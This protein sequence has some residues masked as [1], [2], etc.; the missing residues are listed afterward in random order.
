M[1][2]L[3]EQNASSSGNLNPKA[4][5]NLTRAGDWT[6]LLG[7]V[8]L[9]ISGLALVLVYALYQDYARTYRYVLENNDTYGLDADFWVKMSQRRFRVLLIMGSF[10]TAGAS[11]LIMTAIEGFRYYTSSKQ[12]SVSKS[13]NDAELCTQSIFKAVRYLGFT[14]I[15]GIVGVLCFIGMAVN[16]YF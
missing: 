9:I 10:L 16:N 4:I 12:F 15:L 7:I 1:D 13:A 6:V 3:D 11:L 8:C 14:A 2:I 5:Q